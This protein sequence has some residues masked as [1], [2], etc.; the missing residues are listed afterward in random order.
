MSILSPGPFA[1][2]CSSA[3]SMISF[4]EDSDA[5]IAA[6]AVEIRALE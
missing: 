2:G 1:N 4:D 3:Q 6:Q 5:S